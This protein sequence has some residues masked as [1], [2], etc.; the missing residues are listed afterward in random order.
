MGSH[1]QLVLFFFLKELFVFTD[2]PL[3]DIEVFVR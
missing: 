3:A 2:N 1:D